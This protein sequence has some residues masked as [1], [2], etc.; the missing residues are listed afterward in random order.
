MLK[1][2]IFCYEICRGA[3]CRGEFVEGEFV[4]VLFV[5]VIFVE[6]LNCRGGKWS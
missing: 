5:E 4:E 1:K 6:V 3:N 2:S